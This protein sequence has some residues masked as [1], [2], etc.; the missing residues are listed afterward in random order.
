VPYGS[1]SS[2][3][4]WELSSDRANASRRVLLENALPLA[5]LNNVMGKAA[6]ELLIE[7]NPRDARNRRITLLLLRQEITNPEMFDNIEEDIVEEAPT[8]E[9]YDND[10][11]PNVPPVGTFKKTPGQLEFP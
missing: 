8:G 7:D 2:Y 5:R 3:T 1:G 11:T 4:N 6:T 9:S 10:V